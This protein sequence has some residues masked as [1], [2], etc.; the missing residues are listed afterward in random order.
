LAA[1]ESKTITFKTIPVP[2]G[3]TNNTTTAMNVTVAGNTNACGPVSTTK[4]SPITLFGQNQMRITKYRNF[5]LIVQTG[6]VEYQL[7]ITNI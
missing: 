6:M 2:S 4:T 3:I 1:G 7:P 5:S